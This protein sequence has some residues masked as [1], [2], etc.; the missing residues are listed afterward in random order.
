MR[1]STFRLRLKV[2]LSRGQPLPTGPTANRTSESAFRKLREVRTLLKAWQTINRNAETSGSR[3]TRQDAREF[4]LDLPANLRRIQRELK[5]GYNFAKPFGATPNKGP[6]RSGKRPI[7]VA[8]IRDR[9][10]QRAILDVLQSRQLFPKIADVL[11]TPS[12]IGGIPGRGVDHAIRLFDDAVDGGATYVMGSDIGSFF[13]KIDQTEV[14]AFLER[15]GVRTEFLKLI[16][17]ALKVDLRN[18]DLLSEEL[19]EMF[20]TGT[21]GVA[22]GSPLSALAGNIV[23]RDFDRKLNGRGIVCIRYIDDFIVCGAK[24]DSVRKAMLSAREILSNKQMSI[25]D[26]AT[27]PT[28]AFA[29]PVGGYQVFLGYQLIPGEYPPSEDSC[30]KLLKSIQTTLQAGRAT[31]GKAVSGRKPKSTDRALVQSLAQVDRIV[32][33]WK[34]S[35]KM[36]DCPLLYASVDK[37]IDHRIN[38]FMRFYREKTNGK[39]SDIRRAALGVG[40]LAN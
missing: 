32:R 6:G 2:A 30:S 34:E 24:K 23:L 20:P 4:A 31:I 8:P 13:T 19:R 33:G 11:D 12:S 37:A 17:A 14:L 35:H 27:S 21:D 9:I 36:S 28:K 38:A 10:V 15:A 16:T 26:P 39:P 40:P 3:K 1:Q 18:A 29:G 5:Q 22:Q 7:V 25:Y